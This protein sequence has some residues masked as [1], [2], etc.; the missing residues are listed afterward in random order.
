VPGGRAFFRGE[1][2]GGR[3]RKAEMWEEKDARM[4]NGMRNARAIRKS[5]GKIAASE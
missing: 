2:K 4:F 3:G 1:A 5:R